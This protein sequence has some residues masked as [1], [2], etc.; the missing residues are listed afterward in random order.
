VAIGKVFRNGGSIVFVVKKDIREKYSLKP[1]ERVDYLLKGVV[2]KNM[3][4][5]ELVEG[6][7]ARYI[8]GSLVLRLP[9][10][11][12]RAYEINPGDYVSYEI[13]R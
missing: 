4:I 1:G 13:M 9:I 7:V 5:N 8:S 6:V 12:V 11:I 10:D 2:G 3:F